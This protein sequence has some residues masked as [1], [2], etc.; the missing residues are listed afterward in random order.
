MDL[1]VI[2]MTFKTVFGHTDQVAEDTNK[3]EG[4]FAQIRKERLERTGKLTKD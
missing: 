4:N 3:V 1:K 2:G